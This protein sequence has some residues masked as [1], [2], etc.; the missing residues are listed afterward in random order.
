ME[1]R[2]GREQKTSVTL[3][4][5]LSY[6]GKADKICLV[7]IDAFQSYRSRSDSRKNVKAIL[8]IDI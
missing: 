7:A 4:E 2:N 6:L 8:S 3:D 5:I 1:F